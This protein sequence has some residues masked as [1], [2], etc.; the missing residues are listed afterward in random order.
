MPTAIKLRPIGFQQPVAF[1]PLVSFRIA[2]GVV[3]C[4]SLLR[5]LANGWVSSQ[6]IDPPFHFT[7]VGFG[8]V[9]PLPG[10]G[11]VVVFGVLVL[12]AFNIAVGLAY[13][14]S[15]VVF[16]L[17]FAYL[18]FI[19]QALYL[20]HYYLIV[21]LSFLMIWLPLHKQWSFDA[22]LRPALRAE[23]AP[24]WALYVLRLQIGLVYFYAGIAKLNAD[25]LFDAMP[26][27][28]WLPNLRDLPL[29]GGL[30]AERWV[31]YAMS[32]GGAL[33]D[34]LIPFLLLYRRTRLV[35]FA[36]VIV[37][38][39]LTALLFPVIGMFPWIMLAASLVFLPADLRITGSAGYSSAI[40]R[41]AGWVLIPYFALQVL[42]P[43]R[44][45]LYPGDV[46]WTEEGFRLSWR[47]MLVDKA[48]GVV[49]HLRDPATGRE[50]LQM[51]GDTLTRQQEAQMSYQPDM[52]LQFA[53]HLEDTYRAQGYGDLEVRAEAIVAFNGRDSQPLIDPTVDLTRYPLSLLHKPFILPLSP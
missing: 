16:V 1:L 8:W 28:L 26:L 36:A 7:Y 37:F 49:F 17:L 45:W 44:H 4:I 3:M 30:L 12:C 43:L 51:P 13:R 2:F 15:V 35:A 22:W 47:V 40:P 53:H 50:W 38:H 6:Y 23:H 42:L 48:G 9:A 32:W 31:A 5:T 33:Y 10:H 34:L 27:A 52:I 46:L 21:L 41:A 20:N 25:W 11:M 18:Q 14:V 19:D 24:A 39:L 29:I